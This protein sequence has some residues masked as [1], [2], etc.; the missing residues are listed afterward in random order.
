MTN[1]DHDIRRGYIYGISSY[2]I[3]GGLPI[4]FK[5]IEDIGPTEVVAQRVA[6]S[7]LLLLVVALVRRDLASLF[8][9]MAN[10]RVMAALSASALLIGVNWLVYVWATTH[11]H[12]LAAS[13]GY[14]LNPLISVGLGVLLLKER[15]RRMQMVAIGFALLGVV[16]LALSAL[17]TLWI[18]VV[19][20]L[21]F[22]LYGL[23]RKVTPVEALPG[24]TIETL[25]LLPFAVPYL[26]WLMAD[27]T[28]AFGHR[29]LSTI[30]VPL[31]GLVTSVPLV[32]FAQAARRLPLATIGVLQYL[33]PSLQFLAGYLLYGETLD[34]TRLLS[35]VAIWI[36][37][38]IFTHDALSGLWQR[39]G[40]ERRAQNA[41]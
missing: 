19:L 1:S 36:G 14:F 6:W 7:A 31:L 27:G 8:S 20:A 15:L 25:L 16:M 21:S 10:P 2:L 9:S 40:A 12:I 24:L 29:P 34:S 13:L 3:W 39:R 38:A 35:F 28:M 23:I 26:L 41:E 5:L 18:S 22:A 33:A 4:Y 30:L 17:D 37:L 32:L 11:Q